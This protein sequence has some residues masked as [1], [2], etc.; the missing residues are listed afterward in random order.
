MPVRAPRPCAHPGCGRLVQGTRCDE[1]SKELATGRYEARETANQR[2]Y[3]YR[4]QK[5]RKKYLADN[6]ICLDC[7]AKGRISAATV[8]DH[9][10]PHRGNC[11]LFWDTDN[12]QPLCV[13]CHTRKTAKGK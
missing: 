12:W 1:H 4:W 6:P 2:G 9:V 7:S 3:N 8:V 11:A 13:A 5:A 10:I